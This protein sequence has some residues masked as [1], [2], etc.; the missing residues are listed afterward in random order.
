MPLFALNCGFGRWL[1]GLM[2]CVCFVCGLGCCLVALCLSA[3]PLEY[4]FVRVFAHCLYVCLL[5]CLA[6]SSSACLGG[7]VFVCVLAWLLE[8]LFGCVFVCVLVS[9]RVS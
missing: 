4:S 8:C 3:R 1:V 9:L 7:C 5:A 2:R 6:V